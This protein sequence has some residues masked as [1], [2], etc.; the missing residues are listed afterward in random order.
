MLKNFDITTIWQHCCQDV[1]YTGVGGGGPRGV[2]R[3]PCI[4]TVVITML[5]YDLNTILA[6]HMSSSL[7]TLPNCSLP[8]PLPPPLP[9]LSPLLYPCQHFPALNITFRAKNIPLTYVLLFI[10]I[11]QRLYYYDY[12]LLSM[13]CIVLYPDYPTFWLYCKYSV[14]NRTQSYVTLRYVKLRYLFTYEMKR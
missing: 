1:L 6:T 11:C 9:P 5:I 8:L 7:E 3:L 14:Q 13:H 2:Q 12:G 4:P 10:F